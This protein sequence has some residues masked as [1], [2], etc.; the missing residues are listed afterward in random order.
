M[1]ENSKT[2]LR[3][4]IAKEDMGAFVGFKTVWGWPTRSKYL[5][6]TH[7]VIRDSGWKQYKRRF[8]ITHVPTGFTALKNFRSVRQAQLAA[9]VVAALPLNLPTVTKDNSMKRVSKLD[10]KWYDWLKQWRA[11]AAAGGESNK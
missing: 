7:Q 2:R 3:V 6:V 10:Q 11:G 5:A 1:A 9:A 4:K 8:A